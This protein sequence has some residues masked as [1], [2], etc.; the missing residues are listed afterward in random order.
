MNPRLI[1]SLSLIVLLSAC[2]PKSDGVASGGSS[3]DWTSVDSDSDGI[4]DSIEL[5]YGMDPRNADS[6][7]DGVLDGMDADS[8]ILNPDFVETMT[9]T[10]EMMAVIFPSAPEASTNT[11]MTVPGFHALSTGDANLA[12]NAGT[13]SDGVNVWYVD[14]ATGTKHKLG[15][16]SGL[17][18]VSAAV[19]KKVEDDCGAFKEVKIDPNT[20]AVFY[21]F[22]T[23][24]KTTG[25]GS[26][27]MRISGT[28]IC[29]SGKYKDKPHPKAPLTWKLTTNKVLISYDPTPRT[30]KEAFDSPNITD[31]GKK[32]VHA[33]VQLR[34]GASSNSASNAFVLA[35]LGD[36]NGQRTAD[37]K[38]WGFDLPSAM[39]LLLLL[40]REGCKADDHSFALMYMDGVD[41]ASTYRGSNQNG[42]L[43]GHRAVAA[44]LCPS[45][46]ESVGASDGWAPF[47]NKISF[48]PA[49]QT[50]EFRSTQ[51]PLRA[52]TGFVSFLASYPWS[53]VMGS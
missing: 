47:A 38:F 29:S 23:T 45:T 17:A 39:N 10:N 50:P 26:L 11:L 49:D 15:S 4:P 28:P 33:L 53:E 20:D 52:F 24:N 22:K 48:K 3:E 30:K 2:G 31:S 16:S 44:N 19:A 51:R 7:G 5:K 42:F 6:D 13:Y 9:L 40:P 27:V 21:Q 8:P 43:F 32:G 14:P 36:I 41:I 37:P 1:L 18:A 46:L 35:S 12:T 25:E 34:G